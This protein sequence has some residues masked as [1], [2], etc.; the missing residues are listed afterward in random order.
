MTSRAQLSEAAKH[1]GGHTRLMAAALDGDTKTVK[2]LLES[3]ADVNAKD[4]EGRTALM[5][6]VSNIHIDTVK[7][8]LDHRADVNVRTNDGCTALI[9]AALS[10]E[11]EIV[12]ALLNKGADLSATMA[13]TGKTAQ[14]LAAEKGYNDVAQ[15]LKAPEPKNK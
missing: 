6:A 15:L 3:R 10:G 1:E 14:M 9:L 7:T 4:D 13:Q 12:R 2:G 5:F 8:L 11:S